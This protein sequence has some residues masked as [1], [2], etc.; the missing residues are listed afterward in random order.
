MPKQQ[1]T[2]ETGGIESAAA[3]A[4]LLKYDAIDLS[5]LQKKFANRDTPLDIVSMP[6]LKML[7]KESVEA[8]LKSELKKAMTKAA[9]SLKD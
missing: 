3:Q 7:I 9:E 2:L 1:Y 4:Q 8:A 5:A 6:V